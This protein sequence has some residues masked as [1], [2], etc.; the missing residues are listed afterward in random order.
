M[1]VL[2]FSMMNACRLLLNIR[3]VYFVNAA[4]KTNEVNIVI[5]GREIGT[6]YNDVVSLNATSRESQWMYELRALRW[7]G[8]G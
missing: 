6:K 2:S 5:D 4:H 7:T 8:K 1:F 3:E